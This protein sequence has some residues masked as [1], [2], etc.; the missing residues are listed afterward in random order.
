MPLEMNEKEVEGIAILELR[1]RVTVG[2]EASNLRSRFTQLIEG[3]GTKI[4]VNLKQVDFIDS[5]GLGTLVIGH[6]ITEK[7]G[8][9]MKLVYL[10]KRNMELL[11]MTKLWTVFEV[12]DDEQSAI[13]SFFP[14]REIKRFDILQFVRSHQNDVE[15]LGGNAEPERKAG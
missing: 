13:N 1:G 10:S 5:T 11:I 2:P 8:G 9:A 4:V 12:F 15:H 7:A 14:E 6:S 3:G